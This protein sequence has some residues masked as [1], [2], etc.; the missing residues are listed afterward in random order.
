[1]KRN[2]TWKKWLIIFVLCIQPFLVW[3]YEVLENKSVR[4]TLS[5]S[6]QIMFLDKQNN[7]HWGS[8]FIGWISLR[9]GNI[10]EAISLTKS[11]VEQ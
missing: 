5:D 10:N 2:N 6:G 4:L 9:D 7:Q 1:M 8:D 11:N 3:S